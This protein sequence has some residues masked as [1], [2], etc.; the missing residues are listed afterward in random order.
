MCAENKQKILK[1]ALDVPVDQL[2]DYLANDELITIGQYVTVS[3]GRRK[4]VGVICAIV[5]ESSLPQAKLKKILSVDSEVIFDVQMFQLLNFV[6]D[7]YHFPIGQTILSVVPSR[8]KKN[9]NQLREKE[10]LYKK[11][12]NLSKNSI[13]MLPTRQ[14]R[15]RR[16]A[17]AL[18]KGDIRQTELM[19]LVSNWATCIKKLED[20]GYVTSLVFEPK[21][22]SKLDTPPEL[23]SEQK[24]VVDTISKNKIFNPWVIH[25]ITGSGKTE[26]Y[27]RLLDKFLLSE[28]DQVLVL[29]PEIN[30]T[31]QLEERFRN[32]FPKKKLVS[33]HS[34]LTDIERLDNW[35]MS[36]SG[37]AKIIIG[38]RLSIFTPTLN[39]KLIIIDE[40]HDASFKQQDGLKYHAR[41]VAMIRAKNTDIPIVMGTATPSLETWFNAKSKPQKYKYLKLVNRAVESSNLPEIQTLQVDTKTKNGISKKL[42]DS[43]QLRLD[44]KEQSLVFINRRGFSPVLL[45]SSCG[46]CAECNRCSSKLV[47]HLNKKRLKCHH[48]GYDELIIE[49]CPDCDNG[50]LLPLG[51]GTQKIEEI[52][53]VCF[54][55]ANILRVDR[56]TTRSKK[57]LSDLYKKMNNRS[58]DILV[59]TQ[60]L[61]KGHDFPYLTLVGI[62]DTDNALYSSD[63][64]ASE[65]LFSQILQVSGRAGRSN[66]KGEV[67]IQT[68]FPNHPIFD[69]IKEQ[70]FDTYAD[71]LLKERQEMQLPPYTF[72][73]SLNVESKNLNNSMKFIIDLSEW[74][75]QLSTNVKVFGPVRPSMQK[76]KGYERVRLF[77][78]ASS[79]KDIQNFLSIWAPKISAHSLCNRVRW[80]IDVDP[81]E[82]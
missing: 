23:N 52:L 46:W 21:L 69:A 67:L 18:L 13:D 8:I 22:S 34:H 49:N 73:A 76:I 77:F 31:P 39:L 40:E 80:S 65:R 28:N 24:L 66:I 54:P 17:N 63:F 1:V 15:L 26:V 51:I 58:I 55:K 42:I 79:R 75:K 12:I 70:D 59:G 60:M 5:S 27:M 78:Q 20:L 74:A 30:L 32:R 3:F 61:A 68:A 41:D 6:S 25:G 48:C 29:V 82:F 19:Q 62:L 45:C 44:R 9:L 33:L 71:S 14:L 4:M 56:D 10:K 50:E 37:E 38:T 43:I 16:V 81:I 11:T 35:R 72:A 53:K 7:Y 36:K 64:R 47:V 57:A 2:F